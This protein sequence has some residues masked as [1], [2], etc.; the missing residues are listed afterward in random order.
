[1]P[2]IMHVRVSFAILGA[3]AAVM[4]T[5]TAASAATA[6]QVPVPVPVSVSVG[7]TATEQVS[8]VLTG[9]LHGV[10]PHNWGWE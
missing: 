6:T 4:I 10:L 1:M 9:L 3:V 7:Q 5:G 2:K 8:D